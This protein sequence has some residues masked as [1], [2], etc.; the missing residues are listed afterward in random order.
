MYLLSRPTMKELRSWE[1][2]PLPF[3]SSGFFFRDR[4]FFLGATIGDRDCRQIN[5]DAPVE[6]SR[7]Y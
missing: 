7:G 1:Y 6:W 5:L 3:V 4:G 2:S